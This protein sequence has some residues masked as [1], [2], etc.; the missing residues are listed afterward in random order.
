MVKENPKND[1][2]LPEELK[3]ANIV[4][5]IQFLGENHL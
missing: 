4:F 1:K 3:C 5:Y 2:L